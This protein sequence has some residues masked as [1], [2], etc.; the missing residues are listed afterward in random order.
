MGMP[1]VVDVRD[2]GDRAMR[3]YEAMTILVGGR[4]LSTPGFPRGER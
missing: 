2:S 1:I 3:G 4:V